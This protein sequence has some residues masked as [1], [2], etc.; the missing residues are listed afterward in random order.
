MLCN[1]KNQ[2]SHQVTTIKLLY[3]TY[4]K[5]NTS[6]LLEN[7]YNFKILFG[8]QLMQSMIAICKETTKEILHNKEFSGRYWKFLS[9]VVKM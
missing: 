9:E 4:G 2:E 7:K 3:S 5:Y 6:E 8:E 1:V